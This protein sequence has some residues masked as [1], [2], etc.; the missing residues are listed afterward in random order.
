ASLTSSAAP[1]VQ[2]ATTLRPNTQLVSGISYLYLTKVYNTCQVTNTQTVVPFRPHVLTCGSLCL[3]TPDC[4]G[5]NFW[6][7]TSQCDLTFNAAGGISTTSAVPGCQFYA[8]GQR[9]R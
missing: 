8:R 6:E 2:T 7:K 1:T 9:S 3:R 5:I 4:T